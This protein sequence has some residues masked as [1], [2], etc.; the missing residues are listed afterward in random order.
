MWNFEGREKGQKI[1]LHPG[2]LFL[3][4]KNLVQEIQI[5]N[6]DEKSIMENKGVIYVKVWYVAKRWQLLK[7]KGEFWNIKGGRHWIMLLLIQ[8]LMVWISISS[9]ECSLVKRRI[10]FIKFIFY[11]Y[12]ISFNVNS[13]LY[14]LCTLSRSR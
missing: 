7:S 11:T 6:I 9:F 13:W 12:K 1:S 5:L 2:N 4:Q 14:T 8:M 3:F 10:S